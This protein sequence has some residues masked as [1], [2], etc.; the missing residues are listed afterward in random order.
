MNTEENFVKG[1]VKE[2]EEFLEELFADAEDGYMGSYEEQQIHDYF[3]NIIWIAS[4][5]GADVYA[6]LDALSKVLPEYNCKL[7]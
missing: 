1:L 3:N 6:V 5:R 4:L 2:A 7:I